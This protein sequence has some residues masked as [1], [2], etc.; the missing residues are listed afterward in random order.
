MQKPHLKPVLKFTWKKLFQY[1]L[2]GV[3][4]VAPVAITGYLVYWIISTID[5]LVPIFTFKDSSGRIITKNYGVGIIAIIG[6]LILVGFLSSNFFAARMI[7]LFDSLMEKMPGVK[8]VYSSI[9]DFFEALTGDKK[10]FEKAVLVNVDG[11]DVW[12]IGFIT[13]EDATEFELKEHVAVYIPHAYAISGITYLVPKSKV[14]PLSNISAAQAMKFTVSG[15]V[16]EPPE[17]K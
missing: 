17:E 9:K 11:P 16:A 4:I 8:F 7:D 13:L 14:K 3:L 2:Q 15:G 1:F 12:R 6:F 5:N 10:K